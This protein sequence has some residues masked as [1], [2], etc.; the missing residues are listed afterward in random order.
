MDTAR[1]AWT[2]KMTPTR[3][4]PIKLDDYGNPTENIHRR[5]LNQKRR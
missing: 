1:D 4:A 2:V 5:I 3:A